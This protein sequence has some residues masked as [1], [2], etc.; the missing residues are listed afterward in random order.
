MGKKLSSWLILVIGVYLIVV[1]SRDLFRI[2]GSKK[3]LEEA[4]V[5]IQVLEEERVE[6]EEELKL[7]QGDDF[8]EKE[9]RDKLL[10]GKEGEVVVLL[11]ERGVIN[12]TGQVMSEEEGDLKNWQ[13]WM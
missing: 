12:S 3:R 10:L 7:V 8:V 2:V 1:L 4:E 5:E 13:K 6:L 9:A 11:P